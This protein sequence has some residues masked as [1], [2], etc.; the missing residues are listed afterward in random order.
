MESV[1]E[2]TG[3]L[4]DRYLIDLL[5]FLLK[6]D[7]DSYILSI[8]ANKTDNLS[9]KKISVK[10]NKII[11]IYSEKPEDRFIEFVKNNTDIEEKNLKKAEISSLE[12][13][14]RLG[15]ALN[16]LGLIDYTMLWKLVYD[17]QKTLLD[18]IVGINSGEYNVDE[19]T[20][21]SSENIRLDIP[22]ENFILNNIRKINSE[23]MLNK[24]FSIGEKIFL[25]GKDPISNVELEPYEKHILE[26]CFLYKNIDRILEKSELSKSDTLKY[27]HF[28]Y[29]IGILS[30]KKNLEKQ[31]NVSGDGLA[32]ISFSSYEEALKHYNVKYT[33]IYKILS[34]EIGPIAISIL[35]K[36]ID[37]I[38]DNLPVF[39][40][41][42]EIGKN[43]ALVEKKVLKKVWYHDYETYS[44]EFVRGLEELLYAQ[45]FAVKKNLGV[46]YEN[47]IL[48][49]LKG[50][51]N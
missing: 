44:A 7:H 33:M 15:K 47:Q 23:D 4:I 10:K 27:L 19:R 9:T 37:D 24:H 45:I 48:K 22:I 21:E 8:K 1:F 43:G 26:L 32:S 30:D 50:I 29:L 36:S 51:G 11:F 17:H 46:Y 28:F 16:E 5:S 31:N 34:K 13:K 40:K 3:D 20:Y 41:G 25:I 42:A 6:S 35:S 38:R 39:L 18:E 2:L 12:R 49:W 14:I